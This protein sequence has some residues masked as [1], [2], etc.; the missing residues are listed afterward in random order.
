[1]RNEEYYYIFYSYLG[2]KYTGYKHIFMLI[3]ILK[4]LHPLSIIDL[5][6]GTVIDFFDCSA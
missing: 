2:S 3:L 5:I 6:N 4:S 1:M